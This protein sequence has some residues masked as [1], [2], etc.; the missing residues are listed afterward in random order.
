MAALR[1]VVLL[2]S[3]WAAVA[4]ARSPQPRLRTHMRLHGGGTDDGE[5]LASLAHT[6][7]STGGTFGG[8]PQF[9]QDTGATFVRMSA[10]AT[11]PYIEAN[12]AGAAL[13]PTNVMRDLQ[14]TSLLVLIGALFRYRVVWR[15]GKPVQPQVLRTLTMILVA[16]ALRVLIVN[17]FVPL[18]QAARVAFHYDADWWFS[19]GGAV[20]QTATEPTSGLDAGR[21]LRKIFMTWFFTQGIADLMNEAPP[22]IRDV[23]VAATR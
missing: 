8:M 20:L 7:D 2:A 1:H 5:L 12:L 3:C 9:A 10:G 22:A 4:G 21:G 15:V 23:Y 11:Q 19:H 16:N 18:R 14:L 13:D 6:L 17:L